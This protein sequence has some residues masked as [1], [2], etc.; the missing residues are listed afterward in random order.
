[1]LS[2][3]DHMSRVVLAFVLA[4]GYCFA[5]GCIPSNHS[6]PDAGIP[7]APPVLLSVSGDQQA[8]LTWGPVSGAE[9]YNLYW[10]TD[11]SVTPSSGAKVADVSSPFTVTGLVNGVS[12]YFVLT[13]ENTAGESAASIIL[14]ASPAQPVTSLPAPAGWWKRNTV[15][16]HIWVSSF[17]DA[18]SP[19]VMP[20]NWNGNLA[21]ITAAINADY[22]TKLGVNALW[23]S[24]LSQAETIG[25]YDVVDY[26]NVASRYGTNQ[27]LSDLIS[28][29]H[30]KGL[31]VIFDFIPCYTGDLNP[32]FLD[33]QSSLTSPYRDWYIWHTAPAPAWPGTGWTTPSG[34]VAGYLY[35]A[36]FGNGRPDLNYRNA[37]VSATVKSIARAWLDFGFDG[38]RVDAVKYLYEGTT[39][40][41]F[42]NQPETRLWFDLL[43]ADVIDSYSGGNAKMMMAEAW[44]TDPA[45]MALIQSYVKNP[46]TAS[47]EFNVVLDFIAPGTLVNA[48]NGGDA[49]AAVN[50]LKTHFVDHCMT[51]RAA[52]GTFGIFQSNHDLVAARPVTSYSGNGRK[53]YLAAALNFLGQGMPILYYGNEAAMAGSMSNNGYMTL[54]FDWAA[55]QTHESTPDSIW[56]WHKA[57]IELR[58]GYAA[59]DDPSISWLAASNAGVFA[60]LITG[61]SGKRCVVTAN[62]NASGMA[63]FTVPVTAAGAKGVFGGTAS[64]TFASNTLTVTSLPAYGVRV[65]ALDDASAAVYLDHDPADPGTFSTVPQLPAPDKLYLRGTIAGWDAVDGVNLMAKSGTVYSLP[66]TLA[67]GTMYEFKFADANWEIYNFGSDTERNLALSTAAGIYGNSGFGNITFTPVSGRTYTVYF[68]FDNAGPTYWIQ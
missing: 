34:G 37:T 23:L 15:F 49:A 30:M 54:P 63:T 9:R 36:F 59:W 46:S 29:A 55:Q 16:E 58:T 4:A 60:Y 67:G 8:V 20:E 62:L 40:D 12:Y 3:E 22:F 11:P 68:N 43:R 21:G 66:A 1:M 32:W 35:Y 2:A 5:G 13:A 28:A 51:I 47:D 65:Y 25:G 18:A 14:K 33:S 26:M 52:G 27:D 44:I 61:S 6:S 42:E 10:S 56:N 31:R 41:S 57:L 7:V 24:P 48:I 45:D 38:M 53:I 64:D 50:A 39:P 19:G 17:Q